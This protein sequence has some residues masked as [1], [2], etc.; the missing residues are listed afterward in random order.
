MALD[1]ATRKT[2][3]RE[4]GDIGESYVANYFSAAVRSKDWYDQQKDGIIDGADLTY[5]VKTQRYNMAYQGFI[6]AP[7]Q[8]Q[9]VDNVDL[10]IFVRVP[11]LVEHPM[12]IYIYPNHQTCKRRRSIHIR[13]DMQRL[14]PLTKCF[15]LDSMINEQSVRLQWLSEQVSTFKGL[16]K[17]A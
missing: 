3:L 17:A 11:E 14:Y 7:D 16:R 1:T 8:Y 10:L 9:K 15:I 6:I 12:S 2:Y 5:E 13:G 4:M